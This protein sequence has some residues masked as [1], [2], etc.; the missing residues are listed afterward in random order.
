MVASLAGALSAS[1]QQ[2]SAVSE[3]LSKPIRI[4]RQAISSTVPLSTRFGKIFLNATFTDKTAEFVFDTGSPTI[5]NRHFADEIGVRYFGQNI[6]R[7]ANGAEVAMQMALVET[8]EIGDT[9][10]HDVPV[11]VS[12]FAEAPLAA[13]VIGDGIIGSEI[14]DG[15]AWKIDL[16]AATLTVGATAGAV[17]IAADTKVAQLHD[18]GYP[19]MPVVDYK[20][21]DVR[22]KALF[23]TG[24]SATLAL[25]K[26]VLGSKSVRKVLRKGSLRMGKGSEGTSAGGL[27]DLTELARFEVDR[28]SVGEETVRN[29]SGVSRT[30]APSLIGTGFL[31]THIVTLDYVEDRFLFA[32]RTKPGDAPLPPDFALSVVDGHAIITQLFENTNAAK[33]GMQLG[34]H[35]MSIDGQS[36]AEFE[37]GGPCN[38]QDWILN[39]F[40]AQTVTRLIVERN[41]EIKELVL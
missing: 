18:H 37:K 6:G 12:D 36:L 15:S 5:L 26:Q 16:N 3:V 13:C 23:D 7:D 35:I 38:L 34:D 40:D 11:L 4:E 2:P 30:Q 20:I 24:N 22:D 41:G 27:G 29:V 28:V 31:R 10:F 8:I 9:V 21:G 32:T 39:R 14:L 17:G 19:H 1:A 25:Y 33:A